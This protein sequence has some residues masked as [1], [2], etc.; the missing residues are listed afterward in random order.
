[1]AHACRIDR[2][3]DDRLSALLCTLVEGPQAAHVTPAVAVFTANATHTLLQKEWGIVRGL[4]DQSVCIADP[5]A[6][7]GDMLREVLRR[8]IIGAIDR[9][10]NPLALQ[11]DLRMR[12]S[13]HTASS[14]LSA[15]L[16]LHCATILEQYGMPFAQ[17]QTVDVCFGDLPRTRIERPIGYDPQTIAAVVT[18]LPFIGASSKYRTVSPLQSDV[19][20]AYTVQQRKYGTDLDLERDDGMHALAAIQVLLERSDRSLGVIVAPRKILHGAAYRDVRRHLTES[21]EQIWVMDL[22][23]EGGLPDD[24]PLPESDASG[25]CILML[26]RGGKLTQHVRYCELQGLKLQKMHA[27][28]FKSLADFPWKRIGSEYPMYVLLP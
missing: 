3:N 26:L 15:A 5:L 6:G 16:H 17:G 18:K 1:L 8:M 7:T 9:G 4:A 23:G 12:L 22:N 28:F 10:T 25:L 20:H 21:F 27:L 2:G 24:E 11:E 14:T 13:A 19:L